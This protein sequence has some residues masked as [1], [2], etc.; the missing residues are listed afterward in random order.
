MVREVVNGQREISKSQAESLAMFF[1]DLSPGL[2]F[3]AKDFRQS[4]GS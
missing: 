2:A 3:K 1:N 4:Q